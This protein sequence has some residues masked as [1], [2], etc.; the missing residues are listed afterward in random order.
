MLIPTPTRILVATQPVD[1][2]KS[3]DGLVAV[4]ALHLREEPLS[5]TLFVFTNKR[6]TGLRLLVWSYGGFILVYKK[7]EKGRFRLPKADADRITLSETQLA[8]L[9]DGIDLQ[10]GK[11]LP[12]WN[13]PLQRD[14]DPR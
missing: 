1:F 2:R 9:L 3:I 14:T 5:G 10:T 13:P 4:T 7:L 8:Q 11:R 12:R 6:R